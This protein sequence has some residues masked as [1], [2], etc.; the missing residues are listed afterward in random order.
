MPACRTPARQTPQSEEETVHRTDRLRGLAEEYRPTMD[1]DTLH[2]WAVDIAKEA[3]KAAD[4]LDRVRHQHRPIP[5]GKEP[6]IARPGEETEWVQMM[7][8]P[9]C[10]DRF[11]ADDA[12]P[13][14]QVMDQADESLPA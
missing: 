3:A 10:G 9:I 7:G 4:A 6:R 1:A 13:T 14:M 8:C 2:A 11:A 12:C 5:A